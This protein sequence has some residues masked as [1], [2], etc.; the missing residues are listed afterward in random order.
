MTWCG[1]QF[2]NLVQDMCEAPTSETYEKW[3]GEEPALSHF[4][5]LLMMMLA[6]SEKKRK[7]EEGG[8]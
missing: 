8:P 5:G 1:M 6:E 4:A 3:R 7:N 2:W